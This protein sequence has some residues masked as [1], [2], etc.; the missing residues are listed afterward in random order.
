MLLLSKRRLLHVS[1]KI[2]SIQLN[3]YY[4]LGLGFFFKFTFFYFQ[5]LVNNR[6]QTG[7]VNRHTLCD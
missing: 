4:F 6:E 5:A 1:F 2:N 3:K 7:Q